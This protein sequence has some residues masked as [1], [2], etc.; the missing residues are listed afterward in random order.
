MFK[1]MPFLGQCRQ[2]TKKKKL[3]L[4][5][6]VISESIERLKSSINTVQKTEHLTSID[7]IV[8]WARFLKG[9]LALIQE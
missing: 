9:R 4:E 1:A 8:F 6:S 5:D 2:G 3:E 7:I